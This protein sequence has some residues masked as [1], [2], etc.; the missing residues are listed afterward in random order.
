MITGAQR[1]RL[2]DII[3]YLLHCAEKPLTR[4][5]L[6]KLLYFID[7]RAIAT[8]GK[9]ITPLNWVWYTY[10]PFDAE[11]YRVVD[12]LDVNDEVEVT[13]GQNYFGHPEYHISPGPK[14]GY[15]RVLDD[16][17]LAL[18]REVTSEMGNLSPQVLKE[19]SYQTPPM[20]HA[21]D[22]QSRG[23]PLRMDLVSKH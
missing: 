21:Q 10:G 5:S 23:E 17:E 1:R 19:K 4:T 11:V 13:D 6:M 14:A 12:S 8:L 15:Y 2:E 20:K 3:T 22:N 7:L 16:D 9:P 18:I